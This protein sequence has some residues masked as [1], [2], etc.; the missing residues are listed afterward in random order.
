MNTRALMLLA[1]LASASLLQA[2]TVPQKGTASPSA[3]KQAPSTV[4]SKAEVDDPVELSVFEV[5]ADD[6]DDYRAAN[7]SVGTRFNKPVKDLPMQLE[8]LTQAFMNDIGATDLKMGLEFV[9]GVDLDSGTGSGSRSSFEPNTITIRGVNTGQ[10]MRNGFK[11]I[12]PD[13]AITINRVDIIKG[14]GGPLYG[15]G[16]MGGAIYYTSDLGSTKRTTYFKQTF[17]SL[18]FN[19]TE[20]RYT[21]ALNKAKTIGFSL[22]VAFQHEELPMNYFYRERFVFSPSL[23][24]KIG[25]NTTITMEH[26]TQQNDRSNIASTYFI[27]DE[28]LDASG[29]FYGVVIPGK[30]TATS[31]TNGVESATVSHYLNAPD[32]KNYRL[33]GP[34]TFRHERDYGQRVRIDHAFTEN[35]QVWAGYSH[36]M[37]Y[38][39]ARSFNLALRDVTD[40][41]IPMAIR[42][43]PR[44]LAMARPTYNKNATTGVITLGTAQILDIRPNNIDNDSYQDREIWK[45]ELYYAFNIKKTSHRFIAGIEYSAP[46]AAGSRSP[47]TIFYYGTNPTAAPAA[48][49]PIT[50]AWEA[51][52]LDVI[53]SRFRSPTDFTSVKRW[54]SSVISKFPQGKVNPFGGISSYSTSYYYDKNLYANLQSSFFNG[55]F[56]SSVGV[57]NIRSDRRNTVFDAD[58]NFLWQGPAPAGSISGTINGVRRPAAINGNNPSVTLTWLPNENFRAYVNAMSALD[59]GPS[60]SS[61]DGNGVP[62][63]PAS[64][65]NKEIGLRYNTSN[66]KLLITASYFDMIRKKYPRSIPIAYNNVV[67]SPTTGQINSSPFGIFVLT[68]NESKGMD[69][70]MDYKVSDN[71]RV[72]LGYTQSEKKITWIDSFVTPANPYQPDPNNAATWYL[73]KQLAQQAAYAAKGIDPAQRYV[74]TNADDLAKDNIT[75]FLRYDI[76][77]GVLKGVW[78]FLGGRYYGTRESET[79]SINQTTGDVTTAP[80]HVNSH[81]V[82]DLNVGYRHKLAKRYEVEYLLNV[83]NITN[84]TR[85]YGSYWWQPRSYRGSA[86]I[87]F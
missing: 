75:G 16:N 81:T 24:F 87:K 52:P 72:N 47:Q 31:I 14:P 85:F 40:A 77:T 82:Y 74:G 70:K 10:V 11:R 39:Q 46:Y 8:V 68:N 30:S 2:Q 51:L 83:A 19:R 41:S 35:F 15:Q 53:L 5:K 66:G 79:V 12:F 18:G 4:P 3:A 64:I 57:I 73:T 34:D 80:I 55:K 7:T 78:A 65:S 33:D 6:T 61:Y 62:M 26:E 29:N 48:R 20:F 36:E 58:G 1:A 21:T 56:E 43:D 22:P 86:S 44:F 71:F 63:G 27:R 37:Y 28:K 49:T 9:A 23:K 76:K 67:I 25:P 50:A 13:D 54:D 59:P 38:I 42:T 45:S 69:L 32:I 60:Y 84:D 17:G